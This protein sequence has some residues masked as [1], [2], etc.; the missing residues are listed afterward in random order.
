M[1]SKQAFNGSARISN[2][3]NQE[4]VFSKALTEPYAQEG[5]LARVAGTQLG[6]PAEGA[7]FMQ[8]VENK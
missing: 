4:D 5:A 3:Q 2:P 6:H 8:L 1:A 7:Q